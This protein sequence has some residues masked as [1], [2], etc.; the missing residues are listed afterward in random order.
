MCISKIF[1]CNS[2]F[3]ENISGAAAGFRSTKKVAL[4]MV[5]Q[6]AVNGKVDIV[7]KLYFMAYMVYVSKHLHLLWKSPKS[8]IMQ[9]Q[10]A[11]QMC[12]HIVILF[13]SIQELSSSFSA[14]GIR[15][16]LTKIS[17]IK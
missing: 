16:S 1:F 15:F 7:S 4:Q 9:F 6:L 5:K 11:V 3:G 14:V 12:K 17:L 8:P 13:W 2:F 10:K